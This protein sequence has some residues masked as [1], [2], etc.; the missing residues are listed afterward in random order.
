MPGAR[1]RVECSAIRFLSKSCLIAG[2]VL[3]LTILST[4]SARAQ[5]ATPWSTELLMMVYDSGDFNCRLGGGVGMDMERSLAALPQLSLAA[6]IRIAGA[7]PCTQVARIREVDGRMLDERAQLRLGMAPLVAAVAAPGTFM[8]QRRFRPRARI[9][10]LLGSVGPEHHIMA[11]TGMDGV[12]TL[13]GTAIVVRAVAIR[14][15]LLLQ[16]VEE[17]YWRT[18]ER[19][20]YWRP[21]IETGVRLG[22]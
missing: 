15:P 20:W 13:G 10:A 7:G 11:F 4:S 17:G 18:M 2:T 16:A 8:G 5:P 19:E 12:I 3:L 1:G 21:G 6:G 22:W 14:A 9:G